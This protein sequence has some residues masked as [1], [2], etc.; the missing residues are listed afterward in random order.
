VGLP[1]SCCKSSHKT[2]QTGKTG[3]TYH[4]SDEDLN[5]HSKMHSSQKDKKLYKRKKI[6]KK[7]EGRQTK[8]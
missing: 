2:I 6:G 7:R 5:S 4:S 3:K 8:I 1:E